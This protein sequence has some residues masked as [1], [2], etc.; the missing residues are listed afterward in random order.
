MLSQQQFESTISKFHQLEPA[1]ASLYEMG[2]NLLKAEFEIEAYLLILATWNFA[3]FRYI[4][5]TFDL[6]AFRNV[7]ES[8]KPTFERL[9]NQD[10][11]ICNLDEIA[12]EVKSIY[13]GFKALVGQ[14]GASKI[15]HFKHPP[16]F[17]MWDTA[18]RKEYKIPNTASPDD[19]IKFMK[20]MQKEFRHIQ[21]NTGYKTLAKA[22]DEYNFVI[23]HQDRKGNP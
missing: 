21:W 19:Y 13:A 23:V 16:L 2:L 20:L 8:T 14:T 5:T 4:L 11:R 6:K 3:N 15:M 10:F 17:V 7:I 1:R 12:S 22:I 18:I 9:K